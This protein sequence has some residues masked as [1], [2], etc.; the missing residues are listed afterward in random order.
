MGKKEKLFLRV[1]VIMLPQFWKR[2]VGEEGI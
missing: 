1:S 2:G